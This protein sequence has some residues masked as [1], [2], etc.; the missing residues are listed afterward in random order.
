MTVITW[1]NLKVKHTVHG[2]QGVVVATRKG[3]LVIRA[4]SGE[5]KVARVAD[6]KVL[7]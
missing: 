3:L 4:E 7:Q 1:L 5:I 2:W 6:V